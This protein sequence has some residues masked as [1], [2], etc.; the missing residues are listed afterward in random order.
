[1]LGELLHP[2]TG[3]QDDRL[4]VVA[5]VDLEPLLV[6]GINDVAHVL[7]P[8]STQDT[9]EEVFFWES[10]RHLL[11]IRQIHLQDLILHSVGVE[12]LH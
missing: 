11:L 8:Q 7:L 3:D 10:S 1:M 6:G 2:G 5:L 4:R 12:I 9:I